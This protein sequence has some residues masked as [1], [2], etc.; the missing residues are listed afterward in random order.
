MIVMNRTDTSSGT[1]L[2]ALAKAIV[3]EIRMYLRRC[4]PEPRLQR[5]KQRSLTLNRFVPP[6]ASRMLVCQK[7]R[8]ALDCN[9]L[10]TVR[11][12]PG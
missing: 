8:S 9:S 6:H 2:H 10:G 7:I 5:N 12:P 4:L 11:H 3:H 1:V